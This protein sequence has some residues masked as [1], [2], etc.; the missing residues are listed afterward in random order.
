MEKFKIFFF[1]AKNIVFIFIF[2]QF[3]FRP[4]IHLAMILLL[5]SMHQH[6]R[7]AQVLH[8]HQKKR[9]NHRQDLHHLD[10]QVVLLVHYVQHLHHQHPHPHLILFR[11]PIQIHLPLKMTTIM[12]TRA[13]ARLDLRTLL[14]LMLRYV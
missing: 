7:K 4:R 10:H 11:I 8:F 13:L 12:E 5:I 9:N 14:I 6:V 1:T 3:F 2:L